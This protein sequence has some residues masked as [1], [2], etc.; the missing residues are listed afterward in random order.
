MPFK[1]K[2]PCESLGC[3]ELIQI[4]ERYCSKHKKQEQRQYDKQRGSSTQRGYG[5]RW[6]QYRLH[7]LMAHPLCIN[8]DECRNV[9]TVVDHIVPMKRGGSFW[10]PRNHQAMCKSCHDRKTV[11]EDGRWGGG[12]KISTAIRYSKPYQPTTLS[13]GSFSERN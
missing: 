13:I 8:F 10:D 2:K 4:G 7:Y 6:R 1:P 12:N 3:P 11:K 9:S 5:A